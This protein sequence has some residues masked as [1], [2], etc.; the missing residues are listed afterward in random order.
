MESPKPKLLIVDDD[1]D[2]RTQMRWALA[3]DYEVI[4][5]GDRLA[6][7]EILRAQRPALVTLDL[8]LP[9]DAGGASEGFA[10]LTQIQRLPEPPKVVV[11]TG[12][13]EREHA[14]RAVEQGAFDYFCKPIQ[15]EELKVVLRR[16]LQRHLIEQETRELQRRDRQGLDDMIGGSPAMLDVFA[17]IRKVAASDATVLVLGES[18]TGKELVARAIH[19]LSTRQRGAFVAINCGA[20]PDNLLE[21][22][23]FGHE[24]GAFTGAHVQRKG[25]IEMAHG[26]TLFLD[27]IGDLSLPMQVKLLRF[28]QERRIER[29]GGRQEIPVDV[30]VLSATNANLKEAMRAGRFREDL[31]YRIGV[32]TVSLPPLRERGEDVTVLASAFLERSA[33]EAQRRVPGFTRE[34]LAA[35]QAYSWPGNVRELENRVK[36]AVV[37]AEGARITAA[38]LELDA[39]APLEGRGLRDVRAQLERETIQRTLSRHGGNVSRTAAELGLSRPTL[40]TLMEKLGIA[41]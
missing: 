20:I 13:E 23:L 40:Y 17:A 21:S 25:R 7:L 18:G 1:E 15:A 33:A 35:V 11:I 19:R 10:A 32:V 4:L 31:F 38:D 6:A 36:R 30:R 41:R 24:K 27:E 37:M 26:G 22:E 9:P 34:A 14:L 2:L 29:V 16:A 5:A 8:G 39:A 3:G 28:L 12:R